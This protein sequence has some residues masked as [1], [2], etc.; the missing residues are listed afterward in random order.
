ML[1]PGHFQPVFTQWTRMATRNQSI[2]NSI[3]NTGERH[4]GSCRVSSISHWL[5]SCPNRKKKTAIAVQQTQDTLSSRWVTSTIT[6][7]RTL[8]NKCSSQKYPPSS[9]L[10]NTCQNTPELTK[11]V[12][13]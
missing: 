3:I 2:L 11:T 1:L 6:H 8:T 12:E 10:A 9:S 7:L 5:K 4:C 13:I